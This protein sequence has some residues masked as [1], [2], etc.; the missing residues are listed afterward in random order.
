MKKNNISSYHRMPILDGLELLNAKKHIIDFPFHTHN[1]FNIALVLDQ[2][3]T[4]KLNGKTI[5]A[6]VGSL[7]ITNPDEVHST[8]CEKKIGNSF[9]TFYISPEVLK[10]I[11]KGKDVFFE[12]KTIYNDS[13]FKVLYF[14]SENYKNPNIDFEKILLKV[15]NSLVKNY[16]KTEIFKSTEQSLVKK[17]LEEDVFKKFSLESLSSKF[18]MDKYKFLRLFKNETGLTPNNFI[19]SQRIEMSKKLLQTED[20]LLGIA[21]EAGFYDTTHL[22]KHF[23]RFTGV[24]PL[25]YKNA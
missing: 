22:C 17:F 10:K 20:D 5:Q 21:I 6:P 13:I 7:S 2:I 11:N 23:K 4:V 12:D 24:T 15:L 1:T 8:P 16:A 14:L 9:Y 18:G 19:I 3:F 25:E